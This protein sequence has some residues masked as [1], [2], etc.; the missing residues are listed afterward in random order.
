M[1][2]RSSLGSSWLRSSMTG[3]KSTEYQVN[4]AVASAPPSRQKLVCMPSARA[5][6]A[7]LGCVAR[8]TRACVSKARARNA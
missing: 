4:W 8:Y 6:I 5:T 2:I 7:A 3:G 1:T